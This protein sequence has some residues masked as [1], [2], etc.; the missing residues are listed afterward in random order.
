MP[1]FVTHYLFGQEAYKHLSSEPQKRILRTQRAAYQLGLQGPDL[2]FYYLPSYVIDGHNLGSLAHTNETRHFFLGLLNSYQR[3]RNPIDR[4]IAKAYLIGFLG[5]Y[6]L[7]TICHPF[8]YGR[9]H[10]HGREK[11][12]FSRHAYL[13][14]DIDSS[15]LSIKLHCAPSNFHGEDTIH[16]NFRQKRVIANL[17]YDAYCFTFPKLHIRKSTM[18]MGMF[19]LRFGLWLL[20]DTSGQKKVF[21]RFFEKCFLGYPLF[22]PLVASNTLFFRTDPFNLR[23]AEWTN[24]WD[25]TLVSKESF[26]DLYQK[27]EELYLQR[28]QKL[29]AVFQISPG[30]YQ[31]H[32]I[33]KEFFDDYGNFSF[34]S[35]LDCN[36]PS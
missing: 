18:Y 30:S 31:Y 12:Y 21:F 4:D 26:F 1:G 7:D 27:A 5:H 19:S 11:D 10:Y 34:H 13:E 16:V 17:L 2:F 28:I 25:C 14:T 20:R 35:G 32:K 8:V 36:I 22:S 3:I 29:Y 6:T 24:P 9:T 15:L 23:H 33:L